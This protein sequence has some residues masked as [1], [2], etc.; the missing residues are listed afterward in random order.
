[1]ILPEELGLTEQEKKD[2]LAFMKTLTDVTAT[3]DVPTRLPKLEG[4]YAAINKRTIGG[5]F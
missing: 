2:L 1:M 5:I 3:R 4:K